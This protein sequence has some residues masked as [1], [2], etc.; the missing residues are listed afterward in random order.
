[1]INGRSQSQVWGHRGDSFPHTS[2]YIVWHHPGAQDAELWAR[3]AGTH[4]FPF[5]PTSPSVR[6]HPSC[7]QV[8][9]WVQRCSVPRVIR[10][11]E[12]KVTDY[13][14]KHGLFEIWRQD[15]GCFSGAGV[16]KLWPECHIRPNLVCK[17]SWIGTAMPICL[18]IVCSF[19]H[20]VR[21]EF[22]SWEKDHMAWKAKII[23]N[24]VLY[25]KYNWQL[26]HS[27]A[28]K[29]KCISLT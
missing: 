1:M 28:Q 11:E 3:V 8:F 20:S 15:L 24:L 6:P 18:H 5:L 13:S 29:R 16:G 10:Q 23:Y 19:F 14:T 27:P 17:W 22:S 12:L 21:T 2:L 9:A 25:R 26:C 7:L 4:L